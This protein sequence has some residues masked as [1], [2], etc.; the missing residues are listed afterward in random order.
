MTRATGP[1]RPVLAI[2]MGDPASIGPEILVKAFSRLLEGGVGHLDY[3]PLVV[4]SVSC[5][6]A[7]ARQLAVNLPVQS[8]INI[9]EAI[10]CWQS[11]DPVVCVYEP[12][13]ISP[14][15]FSMGCVSAVCGH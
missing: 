8:V 14:S 7:T 6:Q 2:T 12:V 4:G 10:H 15:D 13:Q 1:S 5:L 3:M 9:A 11:G